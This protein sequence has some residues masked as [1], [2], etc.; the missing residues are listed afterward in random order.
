MIARFCWGDADKRKLHW[1]SLNRHATT[2]RDGGL[3]FRKIKAF[4]KYFLVK[5]WQKL[6]KMED[7]LI[8][9]V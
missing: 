1:L 8:A 9:I 5:K 2:K 4:N 6:M 7:S 3:G